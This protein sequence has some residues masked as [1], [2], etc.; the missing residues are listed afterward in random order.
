MCLVGDSEHP[1]GD[2]VYTL[3]EDL[4]LKVLENRYAQMSLY[5]DICLPEKPHSK[6]GIRT[7]LS[8]ASPL[9]QK[10]LAIPEVEHNLLVG[11]CV[12]EVGELDFHHKNLSRRL[13]CIRKI[14]I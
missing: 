14:L 6:T 8:Q 4:F 12:E 2:H 7:K 10:W 1:D 13:S 3:L 9:V 5:A 11:F